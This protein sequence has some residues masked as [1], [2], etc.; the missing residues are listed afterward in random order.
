MR[1]GAGGRWRQA[2]PDAVGAVSYKVVSLKADRRGIRAPSCECHRPPRELARAQPPTR[3]LTREFTGAR[4]RTREDC[5]RVRHE[6]RGP[7]PRCATQSEEQL[8]CAAEV[9][10]QTSSDKTAIR[11]FRAA[12][13]H[14][15]AHQSHDMSRER[16]G[17]VPPGDSLAAGLRVLRQ[18][19]HHR[20]GSRPHRP[21]VGTADEAPWIHPVCGAGRRLGCRRHAG[22]G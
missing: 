11:L 10:E 2:P 17:R 18:A 14:R 20:V 13:D 8:M 16:G 12:E 3:A 22:D 6:S 15:A 4:R 5:A 7:W 1:G 21:R 9:A 19:D